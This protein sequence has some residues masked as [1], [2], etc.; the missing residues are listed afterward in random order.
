VSQFNNVVRSSSIS[1]GSRR[2]G[3][4]RSFPPI[5]RPEAARPAASRL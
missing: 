3:I 2:P 1:M 5:R 4:V